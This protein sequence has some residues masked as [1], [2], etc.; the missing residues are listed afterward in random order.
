MAVCSGVN[1]LARRADRALRSPLEIR[2]PGIRVTTGRR[3]RCSTRCGLLGEDRFS[4]R[5]GSSSARSTRRRHSIFDRTEIRESRPAGRALLAGRHGLSTST[6]QPA[7]RAVHPARHRGR[8]AW[9]TPCRAWIAD[10]GRSGDRELPSR[11][12]ATYSRDQSRTPEAARVLSS[13]RRASD[14]FGYGGGRAAGSRW[15]Q[16]FLAPYLKP[17]SPL[18]LQRDARRL[19]SPP[20]RQPCPVTPQVVRVTYARAAARERVLRRAGK[21]L[22]ARG[23]R[24]SS[25][26]VLVWTCDELWPVGR[27]R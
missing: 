2:G 5:P 6:P 15:P 26:A 7:R 8:H 24:R 10:A 25:P 1:F 22:T 18:F 13:S 19:S 23:A 14:I 20:G 21:S 3:G 17:V 27:S 16:P 4:I 11:S 9:R 12:S